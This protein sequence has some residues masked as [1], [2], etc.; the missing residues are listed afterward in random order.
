MSESSPSSTP[1]RPFA[2]I[3]TVVYLAGF[4][5]ALAKLGSAVPA[6]QLIAF[7]L[8]LGTPMAFA[9]AHAGATGLRR[10]ALGVLALLSSLATLVLGGVLAWLAF[11][12]PA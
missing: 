2:A 5:V 3:A 1:L 8:C 10:T 9:E 12:P 4:G 11:N 7:A 6:E